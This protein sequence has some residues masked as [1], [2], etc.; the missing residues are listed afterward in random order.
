MTGRWSDLQTTNTQGYRAGAAMAQHLCDGRGDISFAMQVA[1]K[2]RHL[3]I[4]GKCFTAL[5][6]T[7]CAFSHQGWACNSMGRVDGRLGQALPS[8]VCR[9]ALFFQYSYSALSL[10]R[11]RNVSPDTCVAGIA[12]RAEEPALVLRFLCAAATPT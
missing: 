9:L 6:L 4:I 7:S 11:E 12:P 3:R 2:T 1:L 8:N 5:L 10:W